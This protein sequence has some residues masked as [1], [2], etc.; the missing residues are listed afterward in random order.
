MP[1]AIL[2]YHY[3]NCEKGLGMSLPREYDVIH[4]ANIHDIQFQ[5]V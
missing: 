1:Y 4:S 2:Q 5:Q 3:N